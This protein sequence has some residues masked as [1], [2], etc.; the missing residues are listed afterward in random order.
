MAGYGTKTMRQGHWDRTNSL[1]VRF[2]S[3]NTRY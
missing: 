3:I 2:G 1:I